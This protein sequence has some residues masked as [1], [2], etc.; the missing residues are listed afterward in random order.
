[1]RPC[2]RG[3][4]ECDDQP[5]KGPFRSVR[6]RGITDSSERRSQR[7]LA[8]LPRL[9]PRLLKCREPAR[10]P[11]SRVE[12]AGRLGAD[13]T[14]KQ[15]RP[16]RSTYLSTESGARKQASEV[17]CPAVVVVSRHAVSRQQRQAPE[18]DT[19]ADLSD[20]NLRRM[21]HL[22]EVRSVRLRMAGPLPPPLRMAYGWMLSS[23]GLNCTWNSGI[24]S[25]S[26]PRSRIWRRAD[27]SACV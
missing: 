21:T 25:C 17:L 3:I 15:T 23:T 27:R 6:G 7:S 4:A 5:L 24:R 10:G 8:Q 18:P 22:R 26:F 16:S 13:V 2:C 11:R 12:F 14:R 1:M 9:T 20:G 19:E